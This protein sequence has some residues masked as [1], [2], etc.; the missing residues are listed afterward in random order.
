M[1]YDCHYAA[2]INGIR[3]M[4]GDTLLAARAVFLS[5]MAYCFSTFQG[6]FQRLLNYRIFL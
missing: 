6:T 2:K 5:A 1:P 4:K 3:A